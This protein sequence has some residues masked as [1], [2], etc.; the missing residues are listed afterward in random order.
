MAKQLSTRHSVCYTHECSHGAIVDVPF[1]CSK[2][3]WAH[4]TTTAHCT[5]K[6]ICTDSSRNS[7]CETSPKAKQSVPTPLDWCSELAA[8]N[9]KSPTSRTVF[10][11]QISRFALPSFTFML[12]FVPYLSAWESPGTDCRI[13]RW[14]DHFVVVVGEQHTQSYWFHTKCFNQPIPRK[15]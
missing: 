14:I 11:A 4:A 1:A 15:L 10:D 3:A 5:R 7:L 12:F 2:V 13:T 8:C 6:H 9:H